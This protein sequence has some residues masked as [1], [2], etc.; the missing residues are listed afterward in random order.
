MRTRSRAAGFSLVE[1]LIAI[2]VLALGLLGLAA[3][4]PAVVTQQRQAT[5]TV[6]GASIQNSVENFLRE[7]AVLNKASRAFTSS[8]FEPN[9]LV[10]VYASQRGW[11]LLTG[12]KT[13]S[14]PLDLSL[15]PALPIFFGGKWCDVNPNLATVGLCLD[16]ATGNMR[17]IG[18]ANSTTAD[19]TG[20]Y[21]QPWFDIP[22]AQRLSPL[23]GTAGAQ[24]LYVWDFVAR[25]V[26]A[27]L[28]PQPQDQNKDIPFRFELQDDSVQVAVFVRRID[29]GIR[30]PPGVSLSAVLTGGVAAADA[31]VP[32]AEDPTTGR[33]TFDGLG[34]GTTPTYSK[35]HSIAYSRRNAPTGATRHDHSENGSYLDLDAS[36]ALVA[37][38]AQSG[39]KLVDSLGT[40]HTVTAFA[41]RDLPPSDPAT[42]VEITPPVDWS[43][44]VVPQMWFT[45]QVPV[46]VFVVTVP[47]PVPGST[48]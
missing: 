27:R 41:D 1:V 21:Q 45:T 46:S 33:P 17:V 31:R 48:F 35:I 3:V 29:P 19:S 15:V 22:L 23:P 47:T 9:T 30:K 12:N 37:Y 10:I 4:F 20:N 32:V 14:P 6:L 43:A 5:D 40:V 2:V 36:N 34:G 11:Q 26:A 13:W 39:Q 24:P 25:R 28:S 38:A 42:S 16:T 18:F 44:L 8:D 7:N